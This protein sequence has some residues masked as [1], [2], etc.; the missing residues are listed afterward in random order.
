MLPVLAAVLILGSVGR[1][2]PVLA[3]VRR[4]VARVFYAASTGNGTKSAV[5]TPMLRAHT[6]SKKNFEILPIHN[7]NVVGV[8]RIRTTKVSMSSEGKDVWS[9]R[10]YGGMMQHVQLMRLLSSARRTKGQAVYSC[11]YIKSSI[12]VPVVRLMGIIV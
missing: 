11:R 4:C 9:L 10:I 6:G 12:A 7:P 2:L 8:R 5:G 3:V 1:I